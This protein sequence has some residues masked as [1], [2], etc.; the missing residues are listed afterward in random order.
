MVSGVGGESRQHCQCVHNT[1]VTHLS[2]RY[3]EESEEHLVSHELHGS[4]GIVL[5]SPDT[6]VFCTGT[7]ILGNVAPTG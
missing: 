7:L 4:V 1:I 2:G 5:L 3:I 6:D